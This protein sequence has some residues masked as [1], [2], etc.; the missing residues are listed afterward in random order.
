MMLKSEVSD[1]T[2]FFYLSGT[3]VSQTA[4]KLLSRTAVS[5][6]A[7]K[8]STSQ[9]VHPGNEPLSGVVGGHKGEI[10]SARN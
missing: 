7:G 8:L 10:R 6:T 3:V 9:W 4:G 2:S 5:Q 1:F